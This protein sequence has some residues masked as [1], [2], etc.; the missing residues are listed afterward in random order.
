MGGRVPSI[1]VYN[2]HKDL[3]ASAPSPNSSHRG[4]GGWVTI[5]VNQQGAG[6]SQQATFLEVAGVDGDPVCVS[7]IGQAW[8]DGTRL[9]WVGDIGA[10]CKRTW[11]YS[12]LYVS[13]TNET[14]HKVSSFFPPI[15]YTKGTNKTKPRCMWVGQGKA[16]NSQ[17]PSQQAEN[18]IPTFQIYTP[19]FGR[20]TASGGVY[21][22][23]NPTSLCQAPSM[24]FYN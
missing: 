6:K 16:W 9:A 20:Q 8:S 10:Y 12:D 11:Y 13:R 23:A 5:T 24:I 17:I 21:V 18:I 15:S 7:Y 19:N 1:K 22:S 14:L 4:P 3:I 2:E